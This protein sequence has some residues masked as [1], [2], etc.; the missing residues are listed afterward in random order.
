MKLSKVAKEVELSGANQTIS[1]KKRVQKEIYKGHNTN[2]WSLILEKTK[3]N[4]Y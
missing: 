2:E 4:L 1:I 3:D